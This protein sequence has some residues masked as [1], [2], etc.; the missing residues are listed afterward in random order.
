MPQMSIKHGKHWNARGKR[1]ENGLV[2]G[3]LEDPKPTH[4]DTMKPTPIIC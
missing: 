3:T 4:V 1:Q 2:A